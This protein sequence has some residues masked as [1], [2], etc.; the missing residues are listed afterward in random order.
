MNTLQKI[1]IQ[2]G[3]LQLNKKQIENWASKGK[4]EDLEFALQHGDFKIREQVLHA[5]GELKSTSSIDFILEKIEDKI[6]IVSLA[7]I[8]ALEKIG[9]DSDIK[10]QMEN[11]LAY[12]KE[13][14][15]IET[16]NRKKLSQR[17]HTDTHHWERTSKKT[18]DN[19]K[20]MLKKPMIGGKWF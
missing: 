20:Q 18:L 4:I 10:K 11:K 19:V 9:V 2:N 8:S 14:E 15:K 6:K 1:A 16:E 5:L 13:K 7:A 17:T 12:W 3:F